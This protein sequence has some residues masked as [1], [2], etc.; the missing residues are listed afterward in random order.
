MHT[1][2]WWGDLMEGDH[3][4]TR[5]GWD[6]NIKSNLEEIEWGRGWTLYI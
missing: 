6:D 4:K 2:F 3:W 5:R 1:G